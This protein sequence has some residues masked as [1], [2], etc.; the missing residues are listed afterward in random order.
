MPA[1]KE[2]AIPFAGEHVDTLDVAKA[3]KL[4]ECMTSCSRTRES[5]VCLVQ[6]CMMWMMCVFGG[7]DAAGFMTLPTTRTPC[8]SKQLSKCV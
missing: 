4:D 5:D 3:G 1:L 6:L 8:A 7:A 2:I